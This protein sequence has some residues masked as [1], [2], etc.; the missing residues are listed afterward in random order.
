MAPGGGKESTLEHKKCGPMSSAEIAKMLD[1][2]VKWVNRW[3][4][5]DKQPRP[6]YFVNKS[7]RGG[8][9]E[10]TFADRQQIQALIWDKVGR[11][12]RKVAIL[13]KKVTGIEIETSLLL[14]CL[15]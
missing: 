9:T 7:G 14:F 4:A 15:F 5:K 2:S 1:R 13:L 12:H 10:L 3:W 8:K 6:T 11:S